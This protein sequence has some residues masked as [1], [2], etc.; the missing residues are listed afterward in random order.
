MV[1][2]HWGLQDAIHYIQ[3]HPHIKHIHIYANNTSAVS[4][5]FDPL[6]KMHCVAFHCQACQFLDDDPARTLS[7]AWVPG[8][9]DIRG[10][11]KADKMAKAA[12]ELA[13]HLPGLRANALRRAKGRAAREW[14]SKWEAKKHVFG[15]VVQT[16]TGHGYT[17]EFYNAFLRDVNS[18]CPCGELL[19]TRQHILAECPIFEG[20]H[21]LLREAS[22]GLS[23]PILMGT[24]KG[25]AA[26][27]EFVAASGTFTR[28]G[29]PRAPPSL[30]A[31]EQEPDVQE[32]DSGDEES[33]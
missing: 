6:P 24:K 23:L 28:S 10:N 32:D 8:H 18:N 5:I 20:H 16:H 30:P 9:Q 12:V 15:R 3:T 19:Q 11:N 2:L 26:L 14:K 25:I 22:N 31:W 29:A 4:A 33:K 21:H 27:T 17:G 13:S 7:V 1:G